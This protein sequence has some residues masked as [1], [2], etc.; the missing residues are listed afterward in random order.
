MLAGIKYATLWLRCP[1]DY[2]KNK[3][4]ERNLSKKRKNHNENG[5][6]NG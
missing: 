4:R 6:M 3:E 1:A 2:L 5:K